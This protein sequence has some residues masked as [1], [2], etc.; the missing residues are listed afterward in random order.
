M[1]DLRYSRF[2]LAEVFKRFYIF[3]IWLPL[4]PV[5]E[6]TDES[7]KKNE[8]GDEKANELVLHHYDEYNRII[9]HYYYNYY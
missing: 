8:I 1:L 9:S 3:V 7:E 4:H 2:Y 6:C 5:I